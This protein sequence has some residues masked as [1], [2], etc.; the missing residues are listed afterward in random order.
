MKHVLIVQDYLSQAE[1]ILGEFNARNPESYF[2]VLDLFPD[3]I[4]LLEQSGIP[5]TVE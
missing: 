2:V 4:S 5:F 1:L 3:Q